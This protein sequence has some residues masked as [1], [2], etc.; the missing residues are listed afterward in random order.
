LKSPSPTPPHDPTDPTNQNPT[1]QKTGK[2]G[3]LAHP[4]AKQ[5][6]T[7]CILSFDLFGC[8][9]ISFFFQKF[10]GTLVGFG[11]Q[12]NPKDPYFLLSLEDDEEAVIIAGLC[13]R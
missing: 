6:K 13:I 3:H 7:G 10:L 5:E 9:L 2:W 12:T 8:F 11:N 1:S 4:A